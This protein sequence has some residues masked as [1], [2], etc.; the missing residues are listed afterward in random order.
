MAVHA[1]CWW[2]SEPR[3][4]ALN[5]AGSVLTPKK[6]KLSARKSA[7]ESDENASHKHKK[8]SKKKKSKRKNSTASHSTSLGTNSILEMVE[9]LSGDSKLLANSLHSTPFHAPVK[10]TLPPAQNSFNTS[11]PIEN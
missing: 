11:T 10:P 2:M 6:R 9:K 3:P 4:L 8:K 7:S 5:E 1:I